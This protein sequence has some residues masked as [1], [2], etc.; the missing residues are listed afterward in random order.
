MSTQ[1]LKTKTF[2]LL[3]NIYLDSLTAKFH[4]KL[5]KLGQAIIIC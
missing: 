2:V 5:E 4:K 3:I 1:K